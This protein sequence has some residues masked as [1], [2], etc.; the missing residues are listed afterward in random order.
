VAFN[1]EDAAAVAAAAFAA[2]ARSATH[3]K[4]DVHPLEGLQAQAEAQS[5]ACT[6][7]TAAA[8]CAQVQTW[9]PCI[10]ALHLL[11]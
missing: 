10:A 5:Q 11:L 7:D 2:F 8:G 9:R 3:G 4:L 1:Q 6:S